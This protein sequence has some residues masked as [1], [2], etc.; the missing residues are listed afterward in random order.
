MIRK[1]LIDAGYAAR[2]TSS[3]GSHKAQVTTIDQCDQLTDVA[4]YLGSYLS[5]LAEV[6]ECV[7]FISV[8]WS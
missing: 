6:R 2:V 7:D 5:S 4:A 8:R 1:A 3:P